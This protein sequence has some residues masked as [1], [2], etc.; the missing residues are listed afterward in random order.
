[1][2][3]AFNIMFG[4]AVRDLAGRLLGIVSMALSTEAVVSLLGSLLV[5]LA[6]TEGKAARFE[7]V[8]GALSAAGYVLAQCLT[9]A[10]C[11][12]KKTIIN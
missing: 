4:C 6:N 9:G 8:E 10:P 11:L 2:K 7:E 12:G 3:R 1:M 5:P